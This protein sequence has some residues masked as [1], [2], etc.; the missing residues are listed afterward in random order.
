MWH[1]STPTARSLSHSPSAPPPSFTQSPY[2]PRSLVRDEQTHPHRP[3]LV[4]S[5]S[6]CPPLSSSTH[7]NSFVIGPAVIKHTHTLVLNF[8]F[9]PTPPHP[10]DAGHPLHLSEE[11]IAQRRRKLQKGWE[12]LQHFSATSEKDKTDPLSEEQLHRKVQKGREALQQFRVTKDAKDIAAPGV[13]AHRFRDTLEGHDNIT[14]RFFAP[15]ENPFKIV[16]PRRAMR[17]LGSSA[18][19]TALPRAQ[20]LAL[21]RHKF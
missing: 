11:H 13:A 19:L 17:R 3:W 1:S 16:P 15:D 8:S 14:G 9:L 4:V 2:P 6:T 20:S 21:R 10:A 18:L 12:V 7:A 5:H